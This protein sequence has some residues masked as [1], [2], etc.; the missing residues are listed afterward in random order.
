[1]K[2]MLITFFDIKVIVY[3]EFIP[4][5]QT[6]NHAYYAEMLKRLYETVRIKR[7]EL[8]SNDCILQHDNAQ[9]HK[10][11]S[12][13]QFSAQKSITEI[14]HPPCSPDLSPNDFWLFP[15]VKSALKGRRFQDIENTPQKNVTT[16]LKAIP[17]QEFQNCFQQWQHRWAKC[18]VVQLEYFEGDPSQ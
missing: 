12:V 9:A 8:W 5:G 18:I 1:M 11:L 6:L 7:P 16:A 17:Q 14:E 2:T 3:F 10:A 13:K 15:K 4:Q